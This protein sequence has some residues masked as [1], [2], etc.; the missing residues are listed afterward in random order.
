M[1][2]CTG[3]Q[4]Y[5]YEN[6]EK[7]AG[8]EYFAFFREFCLQRMQGKAE[9]TE[10]EEIKQQQR[11]KIMKG[12]AKKIISRGRTDAEN[13]WWVTELLAAD[14]EKAWIHPE[15]E[16]LALV[17]DL[18]LHL[19]RK[20]FPT[21]FHFFLTHSSPKSCLAFPSPLRWTN[22]SLSSSLFKNLHSSALRRAFTHQ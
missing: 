9:L 18:F 19:L 10:G 1:E 6:G 20:P 7:T 12:L 2:A 22:L 3:K 21:L 17:Q 5:R 4:K 14:C 13:R 11:M 8:Q 15:W 16:H